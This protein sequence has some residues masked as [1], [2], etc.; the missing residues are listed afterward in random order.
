MADLKL[1]TKNYIESVEK[2]YATE[3]EKK[4][5]AS[6]IGAYREFLINS[7]VVMILFI[8]CSH[9]IGSHESGRYPYETEGM[10]N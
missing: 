1:A 4:L 6:V 7:D 10:R 2:T 8:V 9:G 5:F 3:N